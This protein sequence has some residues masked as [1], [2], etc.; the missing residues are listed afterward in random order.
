MIQLC[1]C[2]CVPTSVFWEKTEVSNAFKT[3]CPEPCT[4]AVY[5]ILKSGL[6]QWKFEIV[7]PQASSAWHSRGVITSP[8]WPQKDSGETCSRGKGAG[9]VG[10]PK[11]IQYKLSLPSSAS[12]MHVRQ[13]ES[14]LLLCLD[15]LYPPLNM[16]KGL[17]TRLLCGPQVSDKV[18]LGQRFTLCLTGVA[19]TVK[20]LSACSS[21]EYIEPLSWIEKCF[22]QLNPLQLSPE[23]NSHYTYP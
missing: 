21:L 19:A 5:H 1:M 16:K 4:R 13:F 10:W 18:R 12:L 15:S 7:F 2:A 23:P 17:H 14:A 3:S 8:I 20:L 22:L 9:G 6:K 11:H